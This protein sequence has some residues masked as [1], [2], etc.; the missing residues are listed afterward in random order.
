[1]KAIDFISDLVMPLQK[2]DQVA[3]A[4]RIMEENRVG[5]LPVVEGDLYCGLI[6][7]N[8][9]LAADDDQQTLSIYCKALPRP[10]ANEHDHIFQVLHLMCEMKLTL[11]PVIDQNQHY[12]GIITGEMLLAY[13]ANILSVHNPGGIIVLE[14][15]HNDY[16]LSEIARIVE[17]NDTKILSTSIK[18]IPESTR[19]EITLKLNRINVEAVIQT[20]NR[21]EY[22]IKTYYG[23]NEKD[24]ELLRERYESLMTFLKF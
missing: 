1:M 2:S 12:L 17:S 6:S 21:F 18:T 9:L 10:L 7:E 13:L 11:L 22:M 5:H 3:L 24:E 4:L 8:D 19:I 23:E 14:V 20:F 16:S 15:N